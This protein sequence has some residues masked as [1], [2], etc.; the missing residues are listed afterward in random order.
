[1]P[2]PT[3]EISET[4]ISRLVR[5][6]YGRV[7][8]D[9]VLGPVFSRAIGETEPAWEAHFARLT[10]FWLSV[11][12]RTGSYHGDPFSAHLRLPDIAPPMF[13]RWLALFHATCSDLFTPEAAAAFGEKAERIARSL[14][15]GLFER[16]PARRAVAA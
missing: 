2:D 11:M 9:S 12:M 10:A 13:D 6:F 15:M 4:S 1:M 8:R 3:S 16:L 7:R 5:E 14:R